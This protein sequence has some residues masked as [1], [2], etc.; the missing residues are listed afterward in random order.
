MPIIY[1]I[2]TTLTIKQIIKNNWTNMMTVV[3]KKIKLMISRETKNNK[4]N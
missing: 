2:K 4:T 3:L 1:M